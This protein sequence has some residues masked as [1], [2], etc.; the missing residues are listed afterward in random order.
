MSGLALAL[1]RRLDRAAPEGLKNGPVVRDDMLA[2]ILYDPAIP[3]AV[4]G[5]LPDDSSEWPLPARTAAFMARLIQRRNLGRALEFGAGSSSVVLAH[6]LAARGGG[7]L[8]S[9]ER[10][11]EWCAGQWAEVSRLQSVDA[12]LVP[13]RLVFRSTRAGVAWCYEEA[14][15][16]LA[17]R[18]PFDLV[19]VDAP[20]SW[21]GRAGA[22]RTALAHL[23]EGAVI[24]VDDAGREGE[25]NLVGGWLR[26]YPGLSLAA[27]DPEFGR[28]GIAVLVFDG[29]RSV[30]LDALTVA[31][32][33]L[34]AL[35]NARRRRLER[36]AGAQAP[37]SAS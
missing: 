2:S 18:G 3:E 11:P 25:R 14:P 28:L 20:Q 19:L 33:V 16:A 5:V 1:R 4:A 17:E 36:V 32:S 34:D 30:R 21:V 35:R 23:S 7:M 12:R 37:A 22:M 9:L 13:S 24:V 8:T 29:N 10:S 15:A 26:A 27:F 31:G 6:A